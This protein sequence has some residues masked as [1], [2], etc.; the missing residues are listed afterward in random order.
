MKIG[1]ILSQGTVLTTGYGIYCPH[2]N[3]KYQ[4]PVY[5]DYEYEC[6]M[7]LNNK[8]LDYEVMGLCKSLTPEVNVVVNKKIESCTCDMFT[9]LLVK[10]CSCGAIDYER[11][12]RKQND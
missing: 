9:V 8:G 10:G 11:S 6:G 5:F 12:K 3:F 7:A 4:K 2:C 1:D